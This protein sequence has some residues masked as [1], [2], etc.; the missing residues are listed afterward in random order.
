MNVKTFIKNAPLNKF[1]FRLMFAPHCFLALVWDE[2]K[3]S[4][5]SE[6][7]K[8]LFTVAQIMRLIV[9]CYELKEDGKFELCLIQNV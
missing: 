7:R 2:E 3:K 4:F 6:N 1:T 5:I 9:G 8:Y